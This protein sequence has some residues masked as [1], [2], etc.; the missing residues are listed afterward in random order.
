MTS[1]APDFVEFPHLDPTMLE[2]LHRGG[3]LAER[4]L[5]D[6]YRTSIACLLG[7]SDPRVVPHFVDM[8]EDIDT[9][10]P[11][12]WETHRMARRWLRDEM[13]LD[14]FPCLLSFAIKSERPFLASAR[15]KSGDWWHVLVCQGT[16]V[17]HD[18]ARHQAPDRE[19]YT[20]QDV[21]E[22][23]DVC[24]LVLTLPYEPTPDAQLVAW[25]IEAREAELEGVGR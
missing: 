16:E 18:T 12:G 15:S 9:T 23:G 17:I 21:L 1:T 20:W 5:G 14:L 13:D 22:G 4:P 11:L 6:C 7:A 2:Q 24:A 8:V 25:S 19:P 3:P 10:L